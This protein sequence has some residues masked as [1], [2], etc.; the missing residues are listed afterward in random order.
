MSNVVQLRVP[1][2]EAGTFSAAWALL[3]ET[4]KRRSDAKAKCEVL[5]NRQSREYGGQAILLGK[6]K[7][8]LRDDADLKRTGGP[9]FQV[10]LRSGRLQHWVETVVD[11][12]TVEPFADT[13]VRAAVL[14]VK[15]EAFCRSYLDRCTVESH[16]PARTLIVPTMYAIDKLKEVGPIMKAHGFTGMRKR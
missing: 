8:Y 6:L 9:G 1:E 5:W 10:L 16:T 15:G 11:A 14:A 3:P 13:A 7:T 12:P 4:M 2:M